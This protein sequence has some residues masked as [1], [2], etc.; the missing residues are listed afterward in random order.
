MQCC[1]TSG[2][3]VACTCTTAYPASGRRRLQPKQQPL[4]SV[5]SSDHQTTGSVPRPIQL[6]RTGVAYTTIPAGKSAWHPARLERTPLA[7]VTSAPTEEAP[8]RAAI[9][10]PVPTP[11]Y[12]PGG[13]TFTV[14]CSTRIGATPRACLDVVIT[15][16]EC[17]PH[18]P[19]PYTSSLTPFVTTTYLQETPCLGLTDY[20]LLCV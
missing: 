17:A 11:T 4:S 18:I 10:G 13:G 14:S 3:Q 7:M 16:A 6:H 9:V 5:H 8:G 20:W 2:F 1:E 12:G 19:A 15:A